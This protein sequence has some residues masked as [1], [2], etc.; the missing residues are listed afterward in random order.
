MR[1]LEE[2]CTGE[3]SHQA[4]VAAVLPVICRKQR[5]STRL[6]NRAPRAHISRTRTRPRDRDKRAIIEMAKKLGAKLAEDDL[7]RHVGVFDQLGRRHPVTHRGPVRREAGDQHLSGQCAL[8]ETRSI[9]RQIL[10]LTL[11]LIAL[12]IILDLLA[13]WRL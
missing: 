3:I 11:A 9:P 2:G 4:S 7:P 1:A 6:A 5:R 13:R 12:V 10:Y 8:V